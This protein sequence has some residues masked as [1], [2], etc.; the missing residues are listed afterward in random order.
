[1]ILIIPRVLSR[2]LSLLSVI[3]NRKGIDMAE[4]KKRKL[5]KLRKT[6][7]GISRIIWGLILVALIYF[8]APIKV[9][10]LIAIF[11]FAGI[12]LKKPFL[13]YFWL[14]VLAVAIILVV[15]IFLPEDN[16]GW[17]PFT[18]DDEIQ[19]LNNKYAVPDDKNAALIYDEIFAN[20]TEKDLDPNISEEVDDFTMENPWTAKQYPELAQW[21]NEKQPLIDKMQ[22]ASQLGN[23]FYKIEGKSIL[24]PGHMDGLSYF[25]KIA[26]LSVRKF[27]LHLGNNNIDKAL[28]I[29]SWL[30]KIANH[31]CQQPVTIDVLVGISLDGLMK[32][33]LNY[34]L[35][36]FDLS[37]EQLNKISTLLKQNKFSW[38]KHSPVIREREKL[39]CKQMITALMFEQKNN[40]FRY[41][42][43][44]QASMKY[45]YPE[46][47]S[48]DYNV[49]QSYWIRKAKKAIYILEW[50]VLPSSP[51]EIGNLIDNAFKECR[52]TQNFKS[53]RL[54][55]NYKYVLHNLAKMNFRAFEGIDQTF[56]KYEDKYNGSLLL[57]A[58]RKYKNGNGSWPNL[59]K[60]LEIKNIDTSKFVYKKIDDGNFILYGIG[61]NKI[62]NGGFGRECGSKSEPGKDDILI[63]PQKQKQL[64]EMLDI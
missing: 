17:K 48:S 23:C 38:E 39:Y 12:F 58:I 41:T 26:Y 3:I 49:D 30:P 35:V 9:I 40:K 11:Y 63:W 15:W 47:V 34:L 16:Q 37:D 46:G 33:K 44:Q 43:D 13:K 60:Q 59:F 31:L 7:K 29:I 51:Y 24:Y 36:S 54:K 62:D 57:L 42:R 22:Q 4:E 55:L 21:L 27:N 19:A 6:I 10:A 5:G 61:V 32:S 28:D 18:F 50:V 8:Q 2:G 25:R 53:S 20:L 64:R 45:F 14:T 56:K 52:K 1:M